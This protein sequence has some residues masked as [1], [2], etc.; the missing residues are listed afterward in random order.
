MAEAIDLGSIKY[1]FESHLEHMADRNIDVEVF[2]KGSEDPQR[3]KGFYD[4]EKKELYLKTGEKTVSVFVLREELVAKQSSFFPGRDI[5]YAEPFR[6]MYRIVPFPARKIVLQCLS[7]FP[8]DGDNV[9]F[10]MAMH[11]F[12][13]RFPDDMYDI[14]YS[15]LID[16]ETT[17]TQKRGISWWVSGSAADDLSTEQKIKFMRALYPLREEFTYDAVEIAEASGDKELLPVLREIKEF[18]EKN[19]HHGAGDAERIIRELNNL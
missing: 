8:D 15:I 4:P 1:E 14:L 3:I 16:P 17:Y 10:T 6:G 12:Q 2:F 7:D 19:S 13:E 11:S 5:V 18:C 9:I